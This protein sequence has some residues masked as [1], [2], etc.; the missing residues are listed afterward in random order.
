M[1]FKFQE[2]IF[3]MLQSQEALHRHGV[4]G[5]A[6]SVLLEI[7]NTAEKEYQSN[8]NKISSVL[9]STNWDICQA[10]VQ[11]INRGCGLGYDEGGCL[12][13]GQMSSPSCPKPS[14]GLRLEWWVWRWDSWGVIRTQWALT[15]DLITALVMD[16]PKLHPG[17]KRICRRGQYQLEIHLSSPVH[18]FSVPL[19]LCRLKLKH[20]KSLQGK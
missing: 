10:T 6:R 9:P 11:L 8:E 19:H 3:T 7:W 16:R 2:I 4:G 13:K 18:N 15:L 5:D 20:L 12:A 1:S 17:K 14:R